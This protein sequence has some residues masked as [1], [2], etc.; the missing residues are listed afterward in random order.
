MDWILRTF[1]FSVMVKQARR[2]GSIRALHWRSTP[3]ERNEILNTVR[4]LRAGQ[5]IWTSV[6]SMGAALATIT[7][8]RLI[9]EG[10]NV[11]PLYTHASPRVE[12]SNAQEL[13]SGLGGN[14]YRMAHGL[15]LI[16]HLPPAGASAEVAANFI[17]LGITG[18]GEPYLRDLG[19]T[20]AGSLYRMELDDTVTHFPGLQEDED[21]YYWSQVGF[22]T[23]LELLI[24]RGTRSSSSRRRLCPA[25]SEHSGWHRARHLNRRQNPPLSL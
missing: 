2:D 20:H 12:Y 3:L 11:G 13:Y 9:Q 22:G 23:I 19:Y 15:D 8:A 25:S 7:A 18:F 4:F 17:P 10:F 16:P 1:T 6:A 24:G 14:H 21:H 5:T